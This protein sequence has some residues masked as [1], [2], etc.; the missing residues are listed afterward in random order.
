MRNLPVPHFPTRMT[1][2]KTK[3]QCHHSNLTWLR[4]ACPTQ[5]GC[6]QVPPWTLLY[7][8]FFLSNVGS[9][10]YLPM[11]PRPLAYCF[12]IRSPIALNKAGAGYL[13]IENVN[14]LTLRMWINQYKSLKINAVTTYLWLS[15]IPLNFFNH[16]T[17]ECHL[18]CFQ[19]LVL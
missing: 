5:R 4:S 9:A 10:S 6:S 1:V 19:I 12:T 14:I 17:T 15:H 7:T 16:S 2:R 13:P 18:S 8:C 3:E 11:W